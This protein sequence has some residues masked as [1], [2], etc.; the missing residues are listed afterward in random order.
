M[1]RAHRALMTALSLVPLL[2]AATTMWREQGAPDARILVL[3]AA[4][5]IPL[6]ALIGLWTYTRLGRPL[7]DHR[8]RWR[9]E[10]E[11]PLEDFAWRRGLTYVSMAPK[12]GELRGVVDGVSV[13]VHPY[14]TSEEGAALV[15]VVARARAS[16][17]RVVVRRQWRL[18]AGDTAT[19]LLRVKTGDQDFDR[20]FKTRA[21]LPKA[22]LAVLDDVTRAILRDRVA[23]EAFDHESESLRVLMRW[24][25]ATSGAPLMEIDDALRLATVLA[26]RREV[27]L[28]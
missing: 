10:L 26:H 4:V 12:P 7:A 1:S 28:P 18:A 9:E 17:Q 23:L 20:L 15:E 2:W 16:R 11:R 22:V 27:A 5:V 25:N 19:G 3:G 14:V 6:T 24:S 13:V 8:Q 21:D